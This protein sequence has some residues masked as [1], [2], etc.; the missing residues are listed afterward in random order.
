MKRA[1]SIR[2]G[3]LKR[4]KTIEIELLRKVLAAQL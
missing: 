1:V 3:S 4:N 2:I